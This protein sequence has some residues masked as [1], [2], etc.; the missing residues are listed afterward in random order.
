VL[1]VMVVI[2][3]VMMIAMVIRLSDVVGD[4]NQGA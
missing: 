4:S 2:M 1:L 3:M